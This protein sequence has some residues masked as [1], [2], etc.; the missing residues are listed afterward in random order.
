MSFSKKMYIAG[1]LVDGTGTIDVFNPANDEKVATV[2]S[3]GIADADRAL[4]AASDAL[5]SWSRTS[6]A[7]RQQWMSKLRDAVIENEEHLR[8]CIH[9]A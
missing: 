2:P 3:A 9:H 7:E 1:E 4:K 8:D 5:P 6:I